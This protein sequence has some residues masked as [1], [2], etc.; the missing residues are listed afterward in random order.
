MKKKVFFPLALI[1]LT[2]GCWVVVTLVW[3]VVGLSELIVIVILGWLL[4]MPLTMAARSVNYIVWVCAGLLILVV[5]FLPAP[6][7]V[8]LFPIQD[9]DPLGT[10]QAF[11]LLV[12]FSLALI[13]LALL[14][15]SG[16]RLYKKWQNADDSRKS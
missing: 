1:V 12:I 16:L 14:L 3:G 5:W 13:V 9:G 10:P 6:V 2:L 8:K 7:F 15:N 11:T 4:L